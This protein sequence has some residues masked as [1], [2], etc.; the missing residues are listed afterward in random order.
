[1]SQCELGHAAFSD[2]ICEVRVALVTATWDEWVMR[3]GTWTF[4]KEP[5]LTKCSVNRSSCGQCPSLQMQSH[6][7]WYPHQQHCSLVPWSEVG[8]FPWQHFWGL[9]KPLVWS[10]CRSSMA[11]RKDKQAF[12]LKTYLEQFPSAH[13]AL[14]FPSIKWVW[15]KIEERWTSNI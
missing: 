14:I 1:M 10:L 11:W 8:I 5:G 9:H 7:S 13:W 4:G 15:A 12:N 6:S 3:R 2:F